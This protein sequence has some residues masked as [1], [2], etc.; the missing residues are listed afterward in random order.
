MRVCLRQGPPANPYLPLCFCA[1]G[2]WAVALLSVTVIP[3]PF[4][5]GL[6]QKGIFRVNGAKKQ[7]RT[8]RA[9]FNTTS[10]MALVSETSVHDVAGII[11][12]FLKDLPEALLTKTLYQPFL[13]CR[14]EYL[15]EDLR[16]Y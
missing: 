6:D 8:L 14:R 7:I 4:S 13:H 12:E 1:I 15:R 3:T 9:E 11:K 2:F 10:N 5:P 16:E